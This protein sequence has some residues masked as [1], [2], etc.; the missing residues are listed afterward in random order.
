MSHTHTF[1]QDDL[2][3]TSNHVNATRTFSPPIFGRWHGSSRLDIDARMPSDVEIISPMVE[4]LMQAIEAS[5]CVIGREF[6]VELALREALNNAVL[7][8]NRL[9]PAKFVELHCRCDLRKGIWLVIKDEGT[10]FDPTTVP[11][12]MRP[13]GLKAE[14]GRGIYLMKSTMD[15][16]SFERGGTEVHMW[17]RSGWSSSRELLGDKTCAE[18]ENVTDLRR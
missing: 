4:Q 12:P 5:G 17:K 10:G 2:A 15:D 9:D 6:A 14:H 11:N 1:V 3:I 8:G 7:H 13:D 16:V 18:K